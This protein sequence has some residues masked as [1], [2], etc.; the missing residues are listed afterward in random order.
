MT[1]TRI[2]VVDDEAGP[3][4]S[5]EAFLTDLDYQVETAV[6][7]TTAIEKI[8]KTS[9][10]III[11]D[12]N[13]PDTQGSVGDAGMHVLKFATENSPETQVII[14]TGFASLENAIKAMKMGAFDYLIKPFSLANLETII[15]RI[16]TYRSFINAPQ[17]FSNYR[18]LHNEILESMEQSTLSEEGRN[19][20][21]RAIEEQIDDSFKVR[22]R[23]ENIIIEQRDSLATIAM[24]AAILHEKLT[25]VHDSESADLLAKISY[26][27]D[28]RL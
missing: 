20:L 27:A 11:T 14:T 23:L 26:I 1:E 13:M 25:P 18:S 8:R 9:F 17:A 22:K 19:T 16:I 15:E 28:R 7:A 2:L 24:H 3:R 4:E 21:L 6:D 5:L 10:D 12:K